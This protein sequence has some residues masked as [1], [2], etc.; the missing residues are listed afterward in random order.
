VTKNHL[1]RPHIPRFPNEI[2]SECVPPSVEVRIRDREPAQLPSELRFNRMDVYLSAI[3]LGENP[4]AT[5]FTVQEET[6]D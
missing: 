2:G 1:K 5:V 4:T 6:K 3:G